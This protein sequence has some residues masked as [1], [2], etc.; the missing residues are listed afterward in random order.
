MSKPVYQ[1]ILFHSP[2]NP[3]M[4]FVSSRRQTRITAIDILTYAAADAQANRF[5]HCTE[6]DLEPFLNRISD[7]TLKETLCNGVAYLHEGLN[8]IDQRIVEQLFESG[9]IQVVVVSLSL[10]WLLS[11]NAYVVIIMDTQYYN[12]KVHAYED[13]PITDVIQMK[14]LYEPLPVESHL[15]HCLHD[16]FNT[17]VVTKTVEN[18]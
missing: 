6:S 8:Q 11:I 15:D 1:S 10:C 16:H 7:A 4:V 18:K 13:Y 17:E 3:V 2:T 12:G 9:A 14:F 5:L